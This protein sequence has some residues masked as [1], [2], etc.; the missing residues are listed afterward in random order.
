MVAAEFQ[1]RVVDGKIDIPATLRDQFQGEVNV[2]LFAVGAARHKSAW[3]DQN[4]RRWELIAKR[5]RQGLT[6]AETQEL[7]ALQQRADEQLAR[8]GRRPVEELERLYAELSQ[9][10]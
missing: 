7:A 6:T 2:I 8:A 1:T 9:E 5:V 3:P 4:R 10:G